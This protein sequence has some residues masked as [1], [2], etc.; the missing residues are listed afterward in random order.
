MICPA[1]ANLLIAVKQKEYI[2]LLKVIL[3]LIILL[4]DLMSNFRFSK[5]KIILGYEIFGALLGSTPYSPCSKCFKTMY[6]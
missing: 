1:P 2:A 6:S 4:L 5:S 3:N